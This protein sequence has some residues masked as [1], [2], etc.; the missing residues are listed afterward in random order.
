MGD[1]RSCPTDGCK[2]CSEMPIPSFTYGIG[3]GLSNVEHLTARLCQER[4]PCGG[5]SVGCHILHRLDR[6]CQGNAVR[7]TLAHD[8][9]QAVG[10]VG[11]GIVFISTD[12]VDQ[13]GLFLCNSLGAKRTVGVEQGVQHELGKQLDRAV[14]YVYPVAV[15][16]GYVGILQHLCRKAEHL[17]VTL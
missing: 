9:A 15:G 7:L 5:D 8:L 11:T 4:T 6:P 2:V 17:I 13:R 10:S 16:D 3:V 1:G 14:Q 12:V